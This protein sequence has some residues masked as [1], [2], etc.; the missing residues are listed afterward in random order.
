M[1][2]LPRKAAFCIAPLLSFYLI[3][4]VSIRF[5]MPRHFMPG[6]VGLALI[7]GHGAAALL[8]N[9]LL[10]RW[11]RVAPMLF[12]FS[13]TFLYGLG[14]SLEIARDS[15]SRTVEWFA[16]RPVDRD[17][18]IA[19]FLIRWHSPYLPGAGFRNF[20]YPW[21]PPPATEALA[22]SMLP[23]FIISGPTWQMG[24][25]ANQFV[26][27]MA[28][29]RLPYKKAAVFDQRLFYPRKTL[30]GFA[31]WPVIRL[32]QSSPTITV[33]ERTQTGDLP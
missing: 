17:T 15:R 22:P 33:W 13:T 29:G 6:F 7:A 4:T 11:L 18:P 19:T 32:R 24:R 12:V 14:S 21:K 1:R 9:T 5:T 10:P 3:V 26:E 16:S 2:H 31:G 23:P 20:S 8:R 27:A 25:A 30:Y 28:A